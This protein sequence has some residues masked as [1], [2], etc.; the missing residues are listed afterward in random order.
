MSASRDLPWRGLT[1]GQ[2]SLHKLGQEKSVE[3]Q[4]CVVSPKCHQGIGESVV[5]SFVAD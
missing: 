1:L 2:E 3:A 4:S 5:E